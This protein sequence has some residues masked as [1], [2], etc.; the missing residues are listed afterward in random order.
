[1][2]DLNKKEFVCELVFPISADNNSKT[3]ENGNRK[4]DEYI[5]FMDFLCPYCAKF[6]AANGAGLK[7]LLDDGAINLK[8]IS[9]AWIDFYSNGHHYS[10]RS[11][12]AAHII[13]QEQPE[14]L[15]AFI[16]QILKRGIQ[17]REA[18]NYDEAVG[19]NEA[20]AKSAKTV[21]ANNETIQKIL[22]ISSD[23]DFGKSLLAEAEAIR[24]KGLIPGT[25]SLFINGKLA[26][27]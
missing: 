14:I 9:L 20:L 15:W 4:K 17:P 24:E 26:N 1:M 12:H 11:S 19:S 16:D 5:L 18:Q 21:G 7:K 10:V 3:P 22:N 27:D 2:N 8:I 13:Q 25:P 23:D 6:H